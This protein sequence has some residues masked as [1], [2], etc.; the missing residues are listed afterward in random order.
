MFSRAVQDS[1]YHSNYPLNEAVGEWVERTG[2]GKSPHGLPWKSLI[3]HDN[4]T[5]NSVENQRPKS[6]CLYLSGHCVSMHLHFV[7]KVWFWRD[8][9]GVTS[10]G[11]A[12]LCYT[13]AEELWFMF[14]RNILVPSQE[15][16]NSKVDGVGSRNTY[17][18]YLFVFNNL[19]L[20]LCGPEQEEIKQHNV[21]LEGNHQPSHTRIMNS[22]CISLPSTLPCFLSHLYDSTFSS[23][24]PMPSSSLFPPS[25]SFPIFLPS[26]HL[27]LVSWPQ[28]KLK[29]LYLHD[30]WLTVQTTL[31]I[32]MRN[33]YL[34]DTQ[35][36]AGR[37]CPLVQTFP[38]LWMS[39]DLSVHLTVC[40]CVCRGQ[41][42]CISVRMK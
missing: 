17:S 37:I 7:S 34:Q 35:R 38:C 21:I 5:A 2:R 4:D 3:S 25:L 24:L 11:C 33:Q 20:P 41:T 40:V 36:R 31:R 29:H 32:N 1:I 13:P 15:S 22:S 42:L 10:C 6:F 9:A 39:G 8:T 30:C 16:L 19:K 14:G 23:L 28:S 12:S 27:R 26:P 18:T